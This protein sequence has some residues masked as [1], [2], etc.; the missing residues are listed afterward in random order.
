MHILSSFARLESVENAK[1]IAMEECVFG[2]GWEKC[3]FLQSFR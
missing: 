1:I 2:N 3:S